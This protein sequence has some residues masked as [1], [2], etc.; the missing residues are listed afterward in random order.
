[1]SDETNTTHIFDDYLSESELANQLG[2]GVRT[3]RRWKALREGPPWTKVGKRLYYKKSSVAAWLTS[4]EHA[5][6]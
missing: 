4:C 5:A 1:M 2:R 3:L 6:A